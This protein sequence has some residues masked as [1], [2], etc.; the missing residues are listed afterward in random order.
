MTSQVQQVI[1][2]VAR[3]LGADCFEGTAREREVAMVSMLRDFGF[4]QIQAAVIVA[5]ARR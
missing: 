4:T 2:R 1:S 5:A 3:I